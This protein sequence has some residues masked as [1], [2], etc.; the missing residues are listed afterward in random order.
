MCQRGCQHDDK[1]R[2]LTLALLAAGDLMGLIQGDPEA[3]FAGEGD[4]DN[5]QLADEL[6]ALM[7][8]EIGPLAC[9]QTSHTLAKLPKTRSGKIL[10]KSIKNILNGEPCVVP[11]T[12]EDPAT[13]DLVKQALA[14]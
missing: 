14:N 12:I 8:A 5:E 9:Y 3:W 11:P 6:R 10:R 2:E 13:L 7:R 4:A 1:R